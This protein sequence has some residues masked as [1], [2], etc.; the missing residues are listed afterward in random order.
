MGNAKR[1]VAVTYGSVDLS[2]LPPRLSALNIA[3]H[4]G[5]GADPGYSRALS[6]LA[7]VTQ[8]DVRWHRTAAD[9]A[10]A[11]RKW[12]ALGRGDEALA[13][14]SELQA[15]LEWAARRPTSAPPHS[16][17]VLAYLTACQKAEAEPGRGH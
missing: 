13:L 5:D 11:A 9:V 3:I 16:E 15:L 4:F 6:K 2:S 12:D 14:G 1:V 8:L 17:L 7:S 10:V